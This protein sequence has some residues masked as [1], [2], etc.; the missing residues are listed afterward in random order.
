[1]ERALLLDPN[2]VNMRYNFA[3]ALVT[4]LHDHEAALDLLQP[5]FEKTMR[6]EPL[7]WTKSDPDLDPDDE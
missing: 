5:L 7:G 4:D 2:N 3:C 1:M 6:A